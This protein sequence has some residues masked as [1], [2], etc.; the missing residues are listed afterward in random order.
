MLCSVVT[1]LVHVE[2]TFGLALFVA[3]LAVKHL[4]L[5]LMDIP[6]VN[7]ESVFSWI[8]SSAVWAWEIFE[9]YKEYMK[10]VLCLRFMVTATVWF[11][12]GCKEIIQNFQNNI[13]LPQS[14][15]Q[16]LANVIIKLHEKIYCKNITNKI[17][18]D[19][20]NNIIQVSDYH[21]KDVVHDYQQIV[22]TSLS[23]E[24]IETISTMYMCN[25]NNNRDSE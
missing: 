8:L 25:S 14:E 19:P 7:F 17:T 4:A 20:S 12:G 1:T 21:Y 15:H 9:T 3:N 10:S 2:G 11:Q 16:R 22:M 6:Y 5:V 13:C 23:K 18:I 24:Y